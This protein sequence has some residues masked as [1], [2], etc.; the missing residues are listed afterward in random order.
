MNLK[1]AIAP[2]QEHIDN[3]IKGHGLSN[4]LALLGIA[5]VWQKFV[6][7][8]G[9]HIYPSG[10]L[11]PQI[12]LAGCGSCLR[13][14]ITLINN[15]I[16]IQEERNKPEVYKAI[17]DSVGITNNPELSDEDKIAHLQEECKDRGIEYH[18]K[19]G[20]KKLSELLGY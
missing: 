9:E 14:T 13:T 10:T 6:I 2:Y 15:W 19:A 1:E 12:D 8:S 7:E 4:R 3:Y 20:V 5:D 11:P 16:R 17:K 18:H